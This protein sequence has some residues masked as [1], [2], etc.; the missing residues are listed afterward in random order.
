MA[1]SSKW[2]SQT[3]LLSVSTVSDREITESH[4]TLNIASLGAKKNLLFSIHFLRPDL[5]PG[6]KQNGIIKLLPTINYI[7]KTNVV[8]LIKVTFIHSRRQFY[9][10]NR[11]CAD[12]YNYEFHRFFKKILAQTALPVLFGFIK[13]SI[14]VSVH[15]HQIARDL[16]FA[17]KPWKR[18]CF[19]YNFLGVFRPSGPSMVPLSRYGV[20]TPLLLGLN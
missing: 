7:K 16:A 5:Q 20:P 8:G 19:S 3:L 4:F 18:G 12:S 15:T 2:S 9:C 14:T 6:T 11:Y 10:F 13:R 17:L 1:S